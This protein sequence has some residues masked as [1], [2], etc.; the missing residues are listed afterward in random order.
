MAT[1]TEQDFKKAEKKARENIRVREDELVRIIAGC[2]A[3]IK[4]GRMTVEQGKTKIDY[5]DKRVNEEI[6]TLILVE[7]RLQTFVPDLIPADIP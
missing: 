4:D 3:A 2:Q 1:Y 5:A 6:A 7:R